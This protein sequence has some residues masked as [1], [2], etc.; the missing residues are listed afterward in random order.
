MGNKTS[1][2]LWAA[3]ERLRFIELAGFWRGWVQRQDLT[4]VFGISVAQASSDVQRYLE[5]NPGALTYNTRRKRYEAAVDMRR[6]RGAGSLAEAMGRFLPGGA[7]VS[8]EMGWGTA[9]PSVE[10]LKMPQRTTSVETE[11]R[12]FLAV[13][14][15]QRVEILYHSVNSGETRWRFIRPHGFAHNGNRW[16]V[17]AWCE[18]HGDY[19]DFVLSRFAEARW[20][21]AVE[22]VKGAA[23]FPKDVAWESWVE[24]VLVPSEQL[25]E[26][27]R[28]AVMYDYGIPHE[29]L[30]MRVRG[31]LE[32]Y[33]RSRLHLPLQ[34]EP[35][36]GDA[37]AVRALLQVQARAAITSP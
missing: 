33:L 27:Q 36:D 8:L 18:Q 26:G 3:Q 16:H 21:E 12:V 24:L 1:E 25:T 23:P 5:L 4:G 35:Q 20:P 22:V 9:G 10:V 13:L 32:N 29:G 17:R 31:A 19:R 14:H 28:R 34:G 2:S 11:R 15:K 7:A 30:R 37:G 6:V